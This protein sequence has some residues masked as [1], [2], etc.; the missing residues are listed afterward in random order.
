MGEK[1]TGKQI[2]DIVEDALRN[3]GSEITEEVQSLYEEDSRVAEL[4]EEVENLKKE[5]AQLQIEDNEEPVSDQWI[6][7]ALECAALAIAKGATAIDFSSRD[8]SWHIA[9]RISELLINGKC[10]FDGRVFT[11]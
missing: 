7:D 4:E 9:S 10:G 1:I 5:L 11:A 8:I 2:R 3:V 6:T